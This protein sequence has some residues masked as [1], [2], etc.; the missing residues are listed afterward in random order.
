MEPG[1]HR[2]IAEVVREPYAELKGEPKAE[3]WLRKHASHRCGR[4][5]FGLDKRAE[6]V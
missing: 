6:S 5:F 1:P 4:L 3:G 2:V